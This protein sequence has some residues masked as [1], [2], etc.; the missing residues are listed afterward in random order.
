LWNT[1][2]EAAELMGAEWE[3]LPQL[4]ADNLLGK[5]WLAQ[6]AEMKGMT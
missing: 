1:I 2:G 6:R 4:A 3:E 5:T